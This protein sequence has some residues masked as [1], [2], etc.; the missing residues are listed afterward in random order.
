MLA[1]N[2]L[3]SWGIQ[4]AL[5]SLRL[6]SS[7]SSL[8]CERQDEALTEQGWGARWFPSVSLLIVQWKP[9]FPDQKAT[10]YTENEYPVFLKEHNGPSQP[11]MYTY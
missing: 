8:T 3:A 7:H 2:P 11:E 9:T 5:F 1:K 10:Q 4:A 6:K